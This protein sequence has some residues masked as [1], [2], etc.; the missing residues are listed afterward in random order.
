MSEADAARIVGLYERHAGKYDIDRSRAL[1]ERAWLDR[2]AAPLARGGSVLDLGCG[3][4]EPI[5]RHL[6]DAGFA[7]TGVDT[8]PSLLAM[9]RRRFPAHAWIEADMRG[10]SL[11]R[12]FDGVLAWDSFFHL[13]HDDQRAMFPVF[14]AHANPGAPLMFT[15]GPRHGIA[16]GEYRGETLF[17]SSLS[18]DD[19]RALLAAHGFSLEAF[20]P[21]DPG[22]GGHTV[23]LAR[24]DPA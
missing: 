23:W 1:F 10:L 24:R 17:H 22:C 6:I 19:Y 21:E 4:G 15:S 5:A 2:F 9:C 7:L 12:L 8:A 14:A 3:M 13:T 18:P 11:G 16:M 20:V